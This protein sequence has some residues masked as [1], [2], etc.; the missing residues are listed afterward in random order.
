MPTLNIT[1]IQMPNI[2]IHTSQQ[3]HNSRPRGT[4]RS[5]EL[6]SHLPGA[7]EKQLIPASPSSR[8]AMSQ[9]K[10]GARP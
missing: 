9:T 1:G 3:M 7:H 10:R 2:A 6:R 8:R 5:G 4:K